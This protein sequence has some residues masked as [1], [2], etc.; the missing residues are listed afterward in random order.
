MIT[1]LQGMVTNKTLISNLSFVQ[2]ANE[3]DTLIKK[4]KK[5]RSNQAQTEMMNIGNYNIGDEDGTAKE[6]GKEKE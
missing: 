2:D 5:E 4:E 3:E 1:Q 6:T